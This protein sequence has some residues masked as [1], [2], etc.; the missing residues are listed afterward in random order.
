MRVLRQHVA[1]YEVREE[2]I[3]CAGNVFVLEWEF[4]T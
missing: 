4:E 2:K 3:G 1:R